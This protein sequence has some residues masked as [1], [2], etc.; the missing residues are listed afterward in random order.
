MGNAAIDVNP[1]QPK[2]GEDVTITFTGDLD[3]TITSGVVE[4]DI[5]LVIVNLSMKIPF[6]SLSQGVPATSG[7]KAVIGPFTLPNIPLIPNVKGTVKVSEQNGEEVT[8]TNFNMP[9]GD[10]VEV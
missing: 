7:I 1:A 3:E 8:C 5:N 4:L 9:I 10:A 2:K 6:K